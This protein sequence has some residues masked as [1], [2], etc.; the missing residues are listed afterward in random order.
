MRLRHFVLRLIVG[1]CGA[2]A[3]AREC[4]AARPSSTQHISA[5]GLNRAMLGGIGK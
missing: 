2:G 4:F 1:L 3:H 5:L